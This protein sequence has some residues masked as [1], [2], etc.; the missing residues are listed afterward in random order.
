M[1]SNKVNVIDLS[2]VRLK[3]SLHYAFR[4]AKE[5]VLVGYTEVQKFTIGDV[6]DYN[7]R[8][9]NASKGA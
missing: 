2:D 7:K 3:G 1:K 9:K 8:F 6:V 5:K 4:G